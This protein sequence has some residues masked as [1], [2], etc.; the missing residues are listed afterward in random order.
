M[1]SVPNRI[2]FLIVAMLILAASAP[3][4]TITGT[5]H[6]GTTNSL[7]PHVD[8]I[9]LSLQNGMDAVANTKT[10]AQGRFKIDYTPAGQMPMLIRVNYKGVNF[11]A[12]LPPGQSSAD[13]NI[14]EPDANP[15]GVQYTTRL[16][17]FQPNGTTLLVGEEYEVQNESKPPKAFYK[18]DG[19]FDFQIP[20]GA[21][22]GDVNAAGPERMPVVQST[23]SRGPNHFA[24]AYAFRPGVSGVR[25]SYQLP[26][27]ANS[28][29]FHL[30]SQYSVQRVVLLAPP[31]VQVSAPGF[32]PSGSEQGMSVYSRDLVTAGTNIDVALSGTAPPPSANGDQ[33]QEQAAPVNGRDSGA[34][35][36][37]VP[38]RLDTLKW[39]LLGGFAAMFLLGGFYLWKRPADAAVAAA[40][41]GFGGDIAQIGASGPRTPRRPTA[42]AAMSAEAAPAAGSAAAATL[43]A[44]DREAGVSLD[45]LKDT[46]FRLELRHQAGTISEQEY[47]EQRAR[48]EKII[49]D[50]LRG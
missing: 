40:G 37:A 22:L 12:M 47:A 32:Q 31:S 13:V 38:P 7:A 30:P 28:A 16:V 23:I 27:A 6:N 15:A 10:D 42:A 1:K 41:S 20:D 50:L 45:E 25:I 14:Y 48:A 21:Q 39:V 4:I 11:H 44:V 19:D 26:Y 9:L 2:G 49:R 8:V 43:A 36:A 17:V 35:V 3:A 18:V 46:M 5:V 24:I 34:P 33:G 29:T